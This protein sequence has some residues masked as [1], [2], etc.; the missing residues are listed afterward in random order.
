MEQNSEGIFSQGTVTKNVKYNF[1]STKQEASTMD[2]TSD[3][4]SFR[5]IPQQ[6]ARCVWMTAGVLS[7]Q[8]C[9]HHYECETCLLDIALRG[10]RGN[11]PRHRARTEFQALA[12]TSA[13]TL[14]PDMLYS[15]NHYWIRTI[16]DQYLRIGFEPMLAD[17]L[18]SLRGIVL[19]SCGQRVTCNQPSGWILF[20]HGT[21]P[22]YSPVDGRVISVNTTLLSNPQILSKSPVE[23]GWLF[24]LTP[25]SHDQYTEN[26]L[27][28]EHADHA[29]KKD[30][31]AFHDTLTGMLQE[32]V[33]SVGPTLMDGGTPLDDIS[34]ILGPEKYL[35]AV[36]RIFVTPK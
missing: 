16:H 15:S 20:S 32:N 13:K 36:K 18:H 28:A 2:I 33:P 31:L 23:D 34:E 3:E 14:N 9:D 5:I 6:E 25:H 30:F 19:P 8:L 11:Q 12:L 7:Y 17:V 1:S 24:E 29:Y 35:E 26:L 21:L 27:T 4:N 10:E 22:I